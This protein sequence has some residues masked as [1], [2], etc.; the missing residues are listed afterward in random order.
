[1][2]KL[3]RYTGNRSVAGSVGVDLAAFLVRCFGLVIPACATGFQYYRE[4]M[5]A[6]TALSRLSRRARFPAGYSKNL[7]TSLEDLYVMT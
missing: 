4:F 5:N 3:H 1:M 2:L 7:W 6:G